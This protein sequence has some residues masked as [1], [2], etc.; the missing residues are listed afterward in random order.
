MQMKNISFAQVFGARD[1]CC[2]HVPSV[3]DWYTICCT[4][5]A[6]WHALRDLNP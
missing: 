6:Y 4:T 5:Q 3:E 1:G 2:P